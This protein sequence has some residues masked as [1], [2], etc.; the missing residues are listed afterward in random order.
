[1]IDG[2]MK[3][4][5]SWVIMCSNCYRIHGAGIG[6]DIGQLY[7]HQDEQWL[8]VGGFNDAD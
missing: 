6:W 4:D 7:Y 8:M 3:Q 5:S 2:K 1:M